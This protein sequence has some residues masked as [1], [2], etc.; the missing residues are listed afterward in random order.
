[1]PSASMDKA[2]GR[3]GPALSTNKSG[4]ICT[5][6]VAHCQ[7]PALRALFSIVTGTNSRFPSV[8]SP[9]LASVCFSRALQANREVHLC[10]EVNETAKLCILNLEVTARFPIHHMRSV[11]KVSDLFFFSWRPGGFKWSALA[12]GDLKP[13]YACVNFSRLSIASVDSKQHLS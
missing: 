1:M 6:T 9:H 12:R 2:E 10:L 5:R 3:C 7:V 8:Q 11:R 4:L 13:V